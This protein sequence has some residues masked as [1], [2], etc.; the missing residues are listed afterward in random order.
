[1]AGSEIIWGGF[2]FFC[3][4]KYEWM[5]TTLFFFSKQKIR[6]GRFVRRR[7][8]SDFACFG[9]GFAFFLPFF[10]FHLFRHKRGIVYYIFINSSVT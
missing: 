7:R 10:F 1:M 4:L 8:R 5:V 9:L 6:E 2:F 3:W